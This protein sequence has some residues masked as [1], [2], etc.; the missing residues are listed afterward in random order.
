MATDCRKHVE[1]AI[2]YLNEHLDQPL[3]VAQVAKS[4]HL[5]EFHFHR[6][7]AA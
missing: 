1:R 4:C 3:T 2:W 6:I 5:S 7:F